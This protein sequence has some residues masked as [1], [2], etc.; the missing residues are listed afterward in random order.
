MNIEKL[1]KGTLALGITSTVIVPVLIGLAM[2]MTGDLRITGLLTVDGDVALPT[3]SIEAGEIEDGQVLTA[4]LGDGAVDASNI[5][6]DAVITDKILN[7]AISTA[8]L[9]GGATLT[10]TGSVICV[11]GARFGICSNV[12]SASGVCNCL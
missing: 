1:V 6:N 3:A 9:L 11:T 8:K 2:A 5:L 7:G 4:E 10:G 12:P